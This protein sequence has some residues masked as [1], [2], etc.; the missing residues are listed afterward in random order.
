MVMRGALINIASLVVLATVAI[1]G[2]E[3]PDA[4]GESRGIA[5]S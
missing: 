4:S 3:L 1:G 5:L 2:D